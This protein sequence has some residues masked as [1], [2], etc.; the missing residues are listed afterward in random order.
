LSLVVVE[1]VSEDLD[2][3][4]NRIFSFFG[5]VESLTKGKEGVYIKINA[6]DFRK[7]SYTSPEVI[8]A[9][10]RLFRDAGVKVYV[11]D[12]STQGNMTRLVFKV[13]GIDR[14]VKENGGRCLYLDEQPPVKVRIGED[15]YAVELPKVVY[16]KLIKERDEN[17]Y[18]ALPKLKTHSMT[19]VT[20][21]VKGQMGLLHHNSRRER[22]NYMLHQFLVDVYRFIRPDF[23]IIDG[24]TA[25]VHGHYPLEKMLDR[26]L[27]P[28][29]VLIGGGDA[30]AVDTVGAKILGYS[31]E[32][33]EHLKLADEQGLGYGHLSKIKIVG[34]ISMF[35][36][37]YPKNP[38]G[39]LPEE[40]K[41]IKGREMACIEGC[42]GNTL[43]VLE[44][45][46]V[47]HGAHAPFTIVCGKGVDMNEIEKATPPVLIVGPCALEET[48]MYF[49]RK[50]GEDKVLTTDK[51]NDLAK[52]T[53]H[54]MKLTGVKAT[55]IVPLNPLETLAT[56]LKA[57]LHGSR[58]NIPPIL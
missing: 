16:E 32:E 1:H 18:V 11:M 34:D 12:N 50:F 57:K 24:L 39:V 55:Q 6:V 15:G 44:M 37:K 47:D 31:L 51:C 25:V 28:M 20:L 8:G 46:H 35:K 2:S 43:M 42:L 52:V 29:N 27:V 36:E 30:V 9:A 10:V 3:S 13:T 33:V 4:L 14:V 53:S 48:A 58:A 40:V 19:T 23:A 26:F 41:V 17:L 56:L 54:L 7:H 45:L 38:L 49:K 22:H 5:G 21:S